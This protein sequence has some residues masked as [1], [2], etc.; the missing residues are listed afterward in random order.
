MIKIPTNTIAMV[1]LQFQD[2]SKRQDYAD[3]NKATVSVDND[4]L[5][6][7]VLTSDGHWV[8]ITPL[9]EGGGTVTYRHPKLKNDAVLSFEITAPA[10][11]SASFNEAGVVL[12]PNPNPP[13]KEKAA[14]PASTGSTASTKVPAKAK[15]SVVTQAAAKANGKGPH[16]SR[17]EAPAA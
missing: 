13:K 16:R 9:K 14:N 8:Q 12:S 11:K 17:A 6:T 2:A 1:P 15:A 5:A 10:V 4:K 7:A 3:A